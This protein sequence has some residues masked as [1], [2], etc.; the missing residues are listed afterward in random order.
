MGA[1]EAVVAAAVAPVAH[2]SSSATSHGPPRRT[3]SVIFSEV[4]A[5]STSSA[6]WSIA[7]LTAHEAW[8]F[9]SSA[10]RKSAR[11]PLTVST[12]TSSTAVKSVLIMRVHATKQHKK[13]LSLEFYFRPLVLNHLRFPLFP[14]L[15]LSPHYGVPPHTH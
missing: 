12:D 13:T 5:R 3:S 11:A 8:A 1:T 7:R 15:T 6:F 9:A 14:L 2:Q 10:P 4:S